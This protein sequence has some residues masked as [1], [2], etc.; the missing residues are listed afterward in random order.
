MALNSQNSRFRK[1]P[2]C[3]SGGFRVRCYVCLLLAM[4]VV[5]CAW[6]QPKE[7]AKCISQNNIE[8]KDLYPIGQQGSIQL[9]DDRRQTQPM[10]QEFVAAFQFKGENIEAQELL[11]VPGTG[12]IPHSQKCDFRFEL[13]DVEENL[14]ARYGIWNPRILIADEDEKKGF[15]EVSIATFVARFPFTARAK[16]IRVLNAE[17]KIVV[18]KDVRAAIKE[19]CGENKNHPECRSGMLK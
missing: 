15:V 19:F 5:G 12:K 14:L 1:K 10:Q 2:L 8:K 11:I 18:S 6:W 16:E 13:I 4:L 17:N 9:V 7:V 3:G